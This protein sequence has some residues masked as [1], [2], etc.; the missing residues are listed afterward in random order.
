MEVVVHNDGTVWNK[1]NGV[2][3]LVETV[4]E[5]LEPPGRVLICGDTLS[6]LP[7]VQHAA[8]RNP[9]VGHSFDSETF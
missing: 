5:T 4:S 3:R 6:D 8:H 7:M 9:Q 2:A 1:A